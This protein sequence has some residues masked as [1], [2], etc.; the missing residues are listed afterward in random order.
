MVEKWV[1]IPSW[2]QEWELPQGFWAEHG[3]P[4]AY[5]GS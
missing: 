1:S 5:I 3:P 4:V 2:S